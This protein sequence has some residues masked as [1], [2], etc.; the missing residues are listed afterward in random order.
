MTQTIDHVS[1]TAFWVAY[2]RGLESRRKDALFHDPYADKLAGDKGARLARHMGIERAM[3]WTM[4]IRTRIID[5]MISEAISDGVDLI[6]NMGAGLDTRPYRLNL[7]E[8][9]QWVEADFPHMIG[10]KA[11]ILDNEQPVC[12]LDRI[13]CN[14]ADAS[15]RG[16]LLDDISAR[17][18]RILVL[19]EGVIPYLNNAAVSDLACELNFRHHIAYW[20]ADYFSPF[21]LKVSA[22][23]GVRQRLEK[24]APFQ[25]DPGES[26]EDWE[27]FFKERGWHISKMRFIGDEGRKLGRDLPAGMLGRFF[28]RFI[29][30]ERL[31]PY[32]QMNGYALLQNAGTTLP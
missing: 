11:D 16:A 20:I 18:K 27:R 10:Y 9:L 32:R 13:G 23:G 2:Y 31:T 1:D 8:T 22:R 17:A 4:A 21:F 6:L 28:M 12:R 25:F 15:G 29:P 26:S 14:L 24:N 30:E 5:N 3:A 19:T 7:P